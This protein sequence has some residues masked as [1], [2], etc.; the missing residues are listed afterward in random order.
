MLLNKIF[1]Q[2]NFEEYKKYH[3]DFDGSLFKNAKNWL[4]Y[5]VLKLRLN[6]GIIAE[7]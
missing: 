3:Y 4:N 5:S 1:L 6:L 2:Y 7:E